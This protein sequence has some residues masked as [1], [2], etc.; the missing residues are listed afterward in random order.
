[1]DIDEISEQNLGIQPRWT[2]IGGV[3]AYA[4]STNI[5]CAGLSVRCIVAARFVIM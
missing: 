1:M 2:P 3:C 4:M 5:S